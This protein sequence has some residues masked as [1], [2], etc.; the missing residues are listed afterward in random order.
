VT[1]IG[2]EFLIEPLAALS[3]KGKAAPLSVFAV[4][5]AHNK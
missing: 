4:Q 5:W 1:A 2:Q 3:V